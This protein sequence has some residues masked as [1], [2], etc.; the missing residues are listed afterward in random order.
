MCDYEWAQNLKSR[1]D[2]K[3][4]KGVLANFFYSNKENDKFKTK[5]YFLNNLIQRYYNG[6]QDILIEHPEQVNVEKVDVFQSISYKNVCLNLIDKDKLIR[7]YKSKKKKEYEADLIKKL[8]LEEECILQM[9]Y[10]AF[11]DIILEALVIR[12]IYMPTLRISIINLTLRLKLV[13]LKNIR[14]VHN[15]SYTMIRVIN[16]FFLLFGICTKELVPTGMYIDI[17]NIISKIKIFISK[18]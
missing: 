12:H 16:L 9:F 11:K 7:N 1:N 8:M 15:C 2:T 18:I 17:L 13:T 3:L 14:K 6:N 4:L 10:Q 5:K